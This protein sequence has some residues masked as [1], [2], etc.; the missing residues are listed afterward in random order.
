[1]THRDSEQK[2]KAL[3]Y[4][5]AQEKA[6]VLN[7]LESQG[8]RIDQYDNLHEI[9]IQSRKLYKR[10]WDDDAPTGKLSI[11]LKY[12][13]NYALVNGYLVPSPYQIITA[14]KNTIND[15]YAWELSRLLAFYP[16]SENIDN[17][18]NFNSQNQTGFFNNK[19]VN[20]IP[21]LPTQPWL[22]EK[23]P[24]KKRPKEAKPG[25]WDK[26]WSLGYDLVSF[27]PEDI[28]IENYFHYLRKKGRAIL[29]KEHS[30]TTEFQNS[31][32]DGIDIKETLR[33]LPTGKLY[34]REQLPIKGEVGTVVI[35]FD[36][37]DYENKYTFQMTWYA[38]HLNE[39]DLVLYSTPPGEKLVG[40]GISQAEYGG[41]LSVYPPRG[42][43]NVWTDKR[44]DRAKTKGER[45][46]IAGIHY[47]DKK[48]IVYVAPNQPKPYLY[49]RAERFG[50]HII[51][52]P[53]NQLS[54]TMLKKVRFFH[55]L[56]DRRLRGIASRYI[57]L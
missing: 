37:I 6:E 52:I 47:S 4:E 12:A 53:L 25:D 29:E 33:N 44:F 7:S 56:S 40:P 41:L 51:Y 11:A 39:S 8:S 17:L 3:F 46:L 28:I 23:I 35:I 1:E 50:H 15:D 24:I 42:I 31:L 43:P 2:N 22:M 10:E 21:H 27:P 14:V 36:E 30:R 48:Y 19:K 26:I 18:N 54:D 49:A 5:K 9:F 55:F 57:R 34:V 32:L 13:R 20:L 45:L 38:E 16:F